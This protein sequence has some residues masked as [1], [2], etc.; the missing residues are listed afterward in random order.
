MKQRI[1]LI[2]L[3]GS[4]LVIALTS[5]DNN[6]SAIS[7]G[8]EAD[9][10]IHI[11]TEVETTLDLEGFAFSCST[12]FQVEEDNTT[13]EYT[14]REIRATGFTT[15]KGEPNYVFLPIE[16]I[17]TTKQG[18]GCYLIEQTLQMYKNNKEVAQLLLAVQFEIAGETGEIVG[19]ARP[20]QVLD[21]K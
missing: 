17:K 4:M 15:T 7:Q 12:E 1:P 18:D 9:G 6:Q 8:T 13:G 20:V 5:C 14:I 16:P 3:M 19:T 2:L 21:A 11:Q 10:I